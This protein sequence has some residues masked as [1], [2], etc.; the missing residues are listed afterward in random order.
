M[1]SYQ[2]LRQRINFLPPP[3]QSLL[4]GKDKTAL[5]VVKSHHTSSAVGP[6]LDNVVVIVP[7]H[8]TGCHSPLHII[9]CYSPTTSS[10]IIVRAVTGLI[11]K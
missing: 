7:L 1:P 10:G 5:V 3:D 8:I 6:D 9:G 4:E 11:H 2:P